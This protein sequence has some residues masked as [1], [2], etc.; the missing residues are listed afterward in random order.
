VVDYGMLAAALI[1]AGWILWRDR[2][3]GPAWHTVTAG[4]LLA[5]MIAWSGHD[6]VL[7]GTAVV[8]LAAM[9]AVTFVQAITGHA[10]HTGSIPHPGR[11]I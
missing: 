9:L 10:R 2:A 6:D 4:L 5:L 8:V 11:A 1:T 7:I 3:S